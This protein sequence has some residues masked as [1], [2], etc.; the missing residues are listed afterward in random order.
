M[1][2]QI[3]AGILTA[4]DRGMTVLTPN[5]RAARTL[6]Q[7][8]NAHQ[9]APS[10]TPPQILAVDTFLANL[11]R[12]MLLDGTESRLLLNPTQQHALWRAIISTDRELST[13]RSADA[14]AELATEAWRLLCLHNGRPRLREFNVST[15][16]RAFARWAAEFDRTCTRNA[17]LTSAQL[18]AALASALAEANLPL[19]NEGVLLIDIDLLAPAHEELLDAIRRAGYAVD[20]LSTALNTSSG[21]LLPAHNATHELEAAAQWAA[22]LL[23]R[24][25]AASIAM[26]VP[27]L[28]DRRAQIDRIFAAALGPT[29][30]EFSLGRPLAE[31]PS[32]AAAL[33]LLRWPLEPLQLEAISALLLSPFFAATKPE[34]A[35]AAAEFDAFELRRANLLR[36]ELSLEATIGLVRSS[37]YRAQRLLPLLQRLRALHRT[38]AHEIPGAPS[39]SASSIETGSQASHSVWADTFRTLL[40]TAGWTSVAGADSL[41]F[42]TRQRFESALDELATLDFDGARVSAPAALESLTRICRHAIFAPES[43]NAPIQILGPLEPGGVPFDALWFLGADDRTWPAPAASHPLIPWH[44]QRDLGMPGASLIRDSDHSQTLAQRL[45]HTAPEVVFSFALHAE[46]GENRPSALLRG[47]S[48]TR[49]DPPE[50]TPAEPLPLD[51]FADTEPLPPLP[52]G[53]TLGGARVLELQAACAFR[54]FAEIR[55]ASSSPDPRE[56]GL[57]ARDRGIQ[58][59]K[60]MQTFWAQL[61]SQ[62]ALRALPR[63]QREAVLDTCI[64]SALTRAASTIQTPWDTAYLNVQRRRLRA[65]LIPWLDFELTRPAFIVRQQEKDLIANIGPL[66][67]KVRADRIDETGGGPLILDYKTGLANP[68]DWLS[69]RPDA[70]Q[71]PLYA[72]LAQSAVQLPDQQPEPLGGVAFALLRAGDDLALTG[73]AD[74]PDVLLKPAKMKLPLADQIEDWRRILT[75]LALAFAHNDPVAEPKSYPQTCGRCGQRILCR[76]DPS[77]LEN[78]AEEDEAEPAHA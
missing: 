5:Q 22:D 68:N 19:P 69:D 9:T 52:A 47:L 40:A 17:F 32:V 7:A 3:P 28:A 63:T 8:F 72:V 29:S 48:L 14:L 33:D 37:K 57:D 18:P 60:I 73:Y 4:L 15:D 58:V 61:Q 13:L 78:L 51:T 35:F 76:L 12:Q 10:W 11:W 21:S 2:S 54:A 56:L 53:I 30:F 59:H 38:A 70:P 36:P 49:L 43:R 67:L 26:V 46:D 16:T 65:L 62:D 71:L 6:R 41:S 24:N 20:S 27:N 42:Q 74:S 45:A 1:G 39:Q 31:T 77:D 75:D 64:E 25:P 34:E 66:Q 50:T 55:L 44:I 23:D